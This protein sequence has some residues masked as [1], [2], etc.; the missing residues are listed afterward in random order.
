[1]QRWEYRVVT[2]N[3]EGTKWSE[4]AL[5]GL[6]LDAGL[7][8]LGAEGWELVSTHTITMTGNTNWVHYNFKR[9]N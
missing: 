7:N 5:E 4:A 3:R 8:T 1:M 6:D 9:P 2:R